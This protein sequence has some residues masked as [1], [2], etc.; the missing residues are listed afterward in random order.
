MILILVRDLTASRY[1]PLMTLRLTLDHQ[2]TGASGFVGSHVV[3]ELLRQ[4]YSVR[5]YAYILSVHTG[6]YT[7]GVMIVVSVVRSHNAPRISKSYESFGDRFTT[8]VVD[9][10]ATSDLSQ[11]VKGL[12][13]ANPLSSGS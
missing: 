13:H 2:V 1:V 5:A 8:S 12:R 11:A 6:Q 7:Y 10:I 4:G 3:D 9:D